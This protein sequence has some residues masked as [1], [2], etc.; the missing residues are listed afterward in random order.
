MRGRPIIREAGG[1][2]SLQQVHLEAGVTLAVARTVARKGM[3]D[4]DALTEGD[5]VTLQ[6][7]AALLEAPRPSGSRTQTAATV[8][9]RDEQALAATR[10]VLARPTVDAATVLLIAPDGAEVAADLLGL[11]N[12]LSS[13]R[14]QP[15]L[16]L[17]VGEWIAGLPSR[18]RADLRIAG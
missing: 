14:G 1:R 13:R 12:A 5:V 18:A 4:P 10:E 17:P 9:A 2:W 3:I 7:A 6:V 16:V 11:M 8:A 15:V